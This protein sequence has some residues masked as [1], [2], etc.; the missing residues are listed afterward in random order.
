VAS[1][2]GNGYIHL[3]IYSLYIFRTILCCGVNTNPEQYS[4]SGAILPME[5]FLRVN[6][7]ASYKNSEISGS[8]FF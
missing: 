2:C 7:L 3:G 5:I 8:V 1:T 6:L 4:C